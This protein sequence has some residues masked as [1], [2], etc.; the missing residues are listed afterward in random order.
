VALRKT[1]LDSLAVSCCWSCC[2]FW[3]LQQVLIRRRRSPRCH[4]F[5][6]SLR[7]IGTDSR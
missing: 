1:H 7:L 4:M 2:L 6:A 5:Q 3:N